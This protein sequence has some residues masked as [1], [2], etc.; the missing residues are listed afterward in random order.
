MT[1]DNKQDTKLREWRSHDWCSCWVC[2]AQRNKEEWLFIWRQDLGI[3]THTQS[4]LL[5]VPLSASNPLQYMQIK[6]KLRAPFTIPNKRQTEWKREGTGEHGK[7]VDEWGGNLG[8]WVSEKSECWWRRWESTASTSE[9]MNSTAPPFMYFPRLQRRIPRSH[10]FCCLEAH[11]DAT[12]Q[13]F[14]SSGSGS[15]GAEG[16]R[17]VDWPSPRLWIAS[18]VPT[19]SA[20]L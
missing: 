11:D 2:V 15:G 10:L 8:N 7:K 16:T 17:A 3:H 12:F 6:S 13:P 1:D 5:T 14:V 19:L 18:P 20:P 9:L 4:R